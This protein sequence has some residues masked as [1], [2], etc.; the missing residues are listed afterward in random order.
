MEHL[1]LVMDQ[2]RE[3]FT[4]HSPTD[5]KSRPEEVTENHTIYFI[6]LACVEW[7]SVLNSC[8]WLLNLNLIGEMLHGF[9][10][11]LCLCRPP[12]SPPGAASLLLQ[13][14]LK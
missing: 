13:N 12:V 5:S 2:V 3:T 7:L 10:K 14:I 11:V 4:E 1:C 6:R 9:Y 8:L